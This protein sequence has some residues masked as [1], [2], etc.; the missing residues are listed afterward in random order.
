M[1]LGLTKKKFFYPNSFLQNFREQLQIFSSTVMH[2]ISS[3]FWGLQ[4]LMLQKK[5]NFKWIPGIANVFFS[6]L[7]FMKKGDF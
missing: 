1:P 3:E 5:Y 2:F 7:R 6:V 4:F